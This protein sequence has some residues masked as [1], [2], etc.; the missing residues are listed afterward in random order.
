[1]QSR[2][3]D[4]LTGA[5]RV[6]RDVVA[7]EVQDAYAADVL[8]GV[9][10]TLDTLASAVDT[11]EDFVRWDAAATIE[12]LRLAGVEFTAQP[13][14]SSVA[15]L[16]S[17]YLDVRAAYERSIPAVRSSA[18]AEAALRTHIVTRTERYPLAHRTRRT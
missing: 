11:H 6:L 13:E 16:E 4:Q 14:G 10:A 12:I 9:I 15:A 3:S 18:D 1:M 17:W 8:R 7:A 2:I 5:A